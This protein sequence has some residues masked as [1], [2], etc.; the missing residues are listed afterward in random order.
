MEDESESEEGE[1]KKKKKTKEKKLRGVKKVRAERAAFAEAV[2][3]AVADLN[4]LAASAAAAAA[5]PSKAGASASSSASSAAPPSLPNTGAPVAIP[6]PLSEELTGSLRAM[7]PVPTGLLVVEHLQAAASKGL[8]H[9]RN[10]RHAEA[11]VEDGWAGGKGKRRGDDETGGATVTIVSKG[12]LDRLKGKGNPWK[13]TQFPRRRGFEEEA[14][15]ALRG[16]G[17]EW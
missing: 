10:A 6:V 8:A 3:T 12:Q 15:K 13:V 16:E 5:A 1:A 11:R 9:K 17:G 14:E 4:Q 7:K 2:E